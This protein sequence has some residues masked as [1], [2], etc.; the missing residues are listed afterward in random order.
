MISLIIVNIL[1]LSGKVS[2]MKTPRKF[3]TLR[4]FASSMILKLDNP[5]APNVTVMVQLSCN[6]YVRGY[7][8]Q[9]VLIPVQAVTS[10]GR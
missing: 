7:L 10:K 6:D 5:I 1:I 9:R 8:F 3:G 4:Y 2:L